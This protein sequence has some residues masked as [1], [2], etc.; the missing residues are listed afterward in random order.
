MKE[1]F[2]STKF[3]LMSALAIALCLSSPNFTQAVFAQEST[4]QQTTEQKA[5]QEAKQ[6]KDK[7]L[8]EKALKLLNEAI[9]ETYTLRQPSNRIHMQLLAA[10]TLWKYDQKRSLGLI[11]ELTSALN[12]VVRIEAE[13]K[14]QEYEHSQLRQEIINKISTLDPNLAHELLLAMRQSLL[15][16]PDAEVSGQLDEMELAIASQL[17]AEDSKNALKI[18]EESLNKGVSMS[19]IPLLAEINKKDKN[20]ASKLATDII[21]KLQT[22]NSNNQTTRFSQSYSVA[23]N[24]FSQTAVSSSGKN[25]SKDEQ[26]QLVS[27]DEQTRRD[28]I[29][30]IV[31]IALAEKSSLE[32]PYWIKQVLSLIKD[33]MPEFERYAKPQLPAIKAKMA[34]FSKVFGKEETVNYEFLQGIYSLS[35]DEMLA[36]AEQAPANMKQY[37]YYAA[38]SQSMAKDDTER[39][40]QLIEQKVTEPSQRAAFM[41]QLDQQIMNKAASQ[42]KID[43]VKEMVS[44]IQTKDDR[45]STLTSISISSLASNDIRT[46]LALANEARS[47]IG[48]KAY[49]PSQLESLTQIAQVYSRVNP[50]EGFTLYLSVID[51]INTIISTMISLEGFNPYGELL[52]EGEIS[53]DDSGDFPYLRTCIDSL[54]ELAK[55]N[56]E[57][58]ESAT[59]RF[60]QPEIGTKAKLRIAEQILNINDLTAPNITPK[61]AQATN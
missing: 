24:L 50:Q 35:V 51:Q 2:Y 25:S 9:S 21:K 28:L 1:V 20:A 3:P 14:A 36:K 38:I 19:L 33:N 39:A 53:L 13:S 10:E 47:L 37:A 30:L 42:G 22:I 46:A 16:T 59:K 8:K 45:I 27:V 29:N 49:N 7:E 18:A 17:A 60:S 56:F 5:E 43:Q 26:E 57:L 61:T 41:V 31:K 12:E 44:K 6:K 40:R 15:Q 34:D 58:A 55:E 48:Q 4:P 23:T 11:R 52:K 54:S 32:D